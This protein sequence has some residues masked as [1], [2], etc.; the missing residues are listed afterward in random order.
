MR[1][2]D[3]VTKRP[4]SRVGN[5]EIEGEGRSG[6]SASQRTWNARKHR[7]RRD[8]AVEGGDGSARGGS[9]IGLIDCISRRGGVLAGGGEG[10]AAWRR[11]CGNCGSVAV[12]WRTTRVS[13]AYHVRLW[14]WRRQDEIGSRAEGC[15][16]APKKFF[17]NFIL[18]FN[19]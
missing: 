19:L 15:G 16:F 10:E 12:M 8:S 2:S 11:V 13:E 7:A 9:T 18:W 3:H 1:R 14:R 6:R 17:E 5:A 4:A